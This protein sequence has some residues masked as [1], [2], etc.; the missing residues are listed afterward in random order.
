MWRGANRTLFRK[1][2]KKRRRVMCVVDLNKFTK[3]V[4]VIISVVSML[5]GMPYNLCFLGIC[6]YLESILIKEE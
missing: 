5:C 2:R 6:T 3:G 1:Q 4:W